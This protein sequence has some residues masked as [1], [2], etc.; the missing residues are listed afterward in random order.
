MGAVPS[1]TEAD[2]VPVEK[3]VSRA[4]SIVL[5]AMEEE[6]D[7]TGSSCVWG[8]RLDLG[9]RGNLSSHHPLALRGCSC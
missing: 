2:Q 4:T 8:E 9:A 6:G 7:R 5:C 3:C 1:K